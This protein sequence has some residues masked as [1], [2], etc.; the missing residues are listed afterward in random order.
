MVCFIANYGK[1]CCKLWYVLLQIMVS[2]VA[3]YGTFC[4]KLWYVLLQI[5]V[6]FVA[7]SYNILVYEMT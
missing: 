5:M 4:C 7:I 6:S 1:F 2:F 3:N